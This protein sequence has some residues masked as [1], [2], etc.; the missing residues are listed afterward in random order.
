MSKP[1]PRI[2][3]AVDNKKK[4][5]FCKEEFLI[6][7]SEFKIHFVD[8]ILI[9]RETAEQIGWKTYE[10]IYELDAKL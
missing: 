7:N 6:Q 1:D 2:Y 4:N 5:N 8:D 3:Q 9:N 10:T